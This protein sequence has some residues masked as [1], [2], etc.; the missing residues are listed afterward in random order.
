VMGREQYAAQKS[1]LRGGVRVGAI[2]V[3][4]HFRIASARSGSRNR[5]PYLTACSGNCNFPY[6]RESAPRSAKAG[7][8]LCRGRQ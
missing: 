5:I 2:V 3:T 7:Q 1:C 8:V 6:L 4:E